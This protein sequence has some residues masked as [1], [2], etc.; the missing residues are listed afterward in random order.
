MKKTLQTLLA[1]LLVWSLSNLGA[2]AQV[3]YVDKTALGAND[4]TSWTNAYKDLQAALDN[5]TSGQIWVADATYYPGGANPTPDSHYTISSAVQLYGG[6][7]GNE[8]MLSQR[9]PVTHPAI[10]NGDF[11]GNDPTNFDS[12]LAIDNALHVIYVDSLIAGTVVIDGFQ[13]KGGVTDNDQNVPTYF[14]KGG[15]IHAQSKVQVR[16]CKFTKNFA[17]SGGAI[18]IGPNAND[19]EVTA[20]EFTTNNT[21]AQSSGIFAENVTGLTISKCEFTNNKTNRGMVYPFRCNNVLIDSCL[22]QENFN[23]FGYGGAVFNWNSQD[24]VVSNS[25][26]ILNGAANAGAINF[27]GSELTGV[28]PDNF[29]IENCLFA[30]NGS[31]DFGGGAIYNSNGDYTIRGCHFTDGQSF[32]GTHVFNSSSAGHQVVIDSC[33]FERANCSGWGGSLTCYGLDAN[34]LISNSTFK[35]NKTANLG[36]A[37]NTGFGANVTFNGCIFENNESQSSAGGAIALQNDSTTVAVLNCEFNFNTSSSSGGAIFSGAS[38]SS[39]IVVVENSYFLGNSSSSG[40]GGAISIDENGDDDISALTVS[41]SIFGLN[42]AANQG[43]ALNLGDSEV[44][45]TSCLFFQNEAKGTGTGGAISN[46]VTDENSA[47]LNIVNSTFAQNIGGLAAGLANW[48]G[49]SNANSQTNLLNCIF[50]HEGGIGYAIE[51]GTP[52]LTSLGGNLCDD[53]SLNDYLTADKD[54]TGEEAT[55]VNADDFDYHLTDDSYGVNDGVTAGAPTTDLEGNPRKDQVD[56]GAYENQT[57]VGTKEKIVAN[58]GLLN[59]SPNP[60]TANTTLLSLENEWTGA[61]QI[62]AVN[63]MGAVAYSGQVF[64]SGQSFKIELPLD[65]LAAGVYS[66]QVSNGSEMVVEK[67]VRL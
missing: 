27:N 48:T 64:K 7:A 31:T 45:I 37:A 2:A 57:A 35:D 63:V 50:W 4:G 3:V 28:G 23:E 12:L 60:A 43:G 36:G 22:F 47:T 46:N 58:T 55:F 1:T 61:L 21:S 16:N 25:N 17:R 67:L 38:E 5:T 53:G 39:S 8:T 65:K 29:I 24:I 26:F 11:M 59:L 30:S 40:T 32:N 33:V 6:F 10:L 66:V 19:S 9:D 52:E 49:T 44:N 20:C 41:N 13:I 56:M 51:D 18:Y 15:G 14:W 34:Y 42:N 54:I 62:R